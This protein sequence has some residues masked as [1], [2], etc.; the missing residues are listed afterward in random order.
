MVS[1]IKEGSIIRV[2]LPI[3]K[4][5]APWFV[6]TVDREKVIA[7]RADSYSCRVF[8]RKDVEPWEKE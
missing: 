3:P 6:V 7:Q 5:D 2:K 4:A 1:Q 8:S